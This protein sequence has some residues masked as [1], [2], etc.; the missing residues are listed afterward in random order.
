MGAKSVPRGKYCRNSRLV[1]SFVPRCQGLCGSQK[2]TCT[3]VATVKS[4]CF[5]I[6]SPRS[7]VNERRKVAGSL[8]TCLLNAATTS[9]V[10]LLGTLISMR[11]RECRSTSVAIYLFF[12]LATATPALCPLFLPAAPH[13]A[14]VGD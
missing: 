5:A 9:A 2:Y 12:S 3:S 7:Q 4:L 6:S 13:A 14:H 8:R 1:F 11:K 10:S